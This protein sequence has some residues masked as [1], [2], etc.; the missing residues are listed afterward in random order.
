MCEP[1]LNLRQTLLQNGSPFESLLKLGKSAML[2]RL[3]VII[4]Y[5]IVIVVIVVINNK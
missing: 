4:K 2:E 5:P 1:Q 3:N